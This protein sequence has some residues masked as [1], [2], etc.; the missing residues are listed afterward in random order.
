MEIPPQPPAATPLHRP[1]LA[2]RGL[3]RA[4]F[5]SLL[6]LGFTALGAVGGLWGALGIR[7]MM[8]NVTTELPARL[9]VGLPQDYPPGHVET[10]Y[11][12]RYG[13]WILHAIYQG[14]PQI[15][16]LRTVC[17]HLGCITIWNETERKFK[18]PCHGSGFQAN[19]INLEG[20][21]PRPLER[22]AIALADDGQL[23]IDRSRVFQEELGQ[24]R[25]P[26]S[27]VPT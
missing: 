12:E 1:D 19:G 18:C 20:P 14:R 4:M 27:Y 8:P 9:K 21:A 15:Y 10:R 11:Q 13:I 16:A 5:G 3:L 2:R 26:A 7:F 24:W 17:T 22:V 6:G 25:D 23:E